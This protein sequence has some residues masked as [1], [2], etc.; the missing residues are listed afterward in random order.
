ME[1]LE[2]D[3]VSDAAYPSKRQSISNMIDQTYS[4]P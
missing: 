1:A 2:N 3:V 4:L